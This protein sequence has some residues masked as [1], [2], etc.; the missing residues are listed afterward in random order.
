MN[1]GSYIVYVDYSVILDKLD[2]IRNVA[3][4]DVN[5]YK[6]GLTTYSLERCE[7]LYMNG[8]MPS[9]GRLSNMKENRPA[10]RVILKHL[11]TT[12]K[13]LRMKRSNAKEYREVTPVS[14][15][16]WIDALRGKTHILI[17]NNPNE[18]QIV[19]IF[20]VND[21]KDVKISK[22]ISFAP[23]F[24]EV[25]VFTAMNVSVDCL[26]LIIIIDVCLQIHCNRICDILFN[27]L[28]SLNTLN[29]QNHSKPNFETV[30]IPTHSK[31]L[32]WAVRKPR[33]KDYSIYMA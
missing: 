10:A 33:L 7:L 3:Y 32:K 9:N 15:R 25:Y 13:G 16:I 19:A 5:G 20:P 6:C 23:F 22:R 26:P 18:V 21:N 30:A 27:F 4:K 11:N 28:T 8:K 14:T 2:C 1:Y 24:V 12:K 29:S 31:L 17:I